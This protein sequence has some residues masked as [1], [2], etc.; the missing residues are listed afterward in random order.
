[1]TA[2][3][4]FPLIYGIATAIT[5]LDP[6]SD[7]IYLI[8]V[9]DA[10]IYLLMPQISIMIIRLV[11]GRNLRHQIVGQTV[12]IGDILWVAQS[13]EAFLS[14][15]RDMPWPKS[16]SPAPTLIVPS[17]TLYGMFCRYLPFRRVLQD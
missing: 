13:A 4:G 6:S 16:Y 5:R 9:L 12:V 1:V 2:V 3:S 8:L 11:H 14:K 10:A 7:W 15:V 17:L